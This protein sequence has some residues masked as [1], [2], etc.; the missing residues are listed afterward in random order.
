METLDSVTKVS[1]SDTGYHVFVNGVLPEER[2]RTDDIIL[3]ETV[4]LSNSL[5]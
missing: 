2:N 1:S 4:R 3:Y 5:N